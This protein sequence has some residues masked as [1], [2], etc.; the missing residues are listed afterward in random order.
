MLLIQRR[1]YSFIPKQEYRTCQQILFNHSINLDTDHCCY[2]S[3]FM[4]LLNPE[5]GDVWKICSKLHIQE[6][7]SILRIV[8]ALTPALDEAHWKDLLSTIMKRLLNLHPK[9]IVAFKCMS[10]LYFRLYVLASRNAAVV[11]YILQKAI[12]IGWHQCRRSIN[13]QYH[14]LIPNIYVFLSVN[15]P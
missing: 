13:I 8:W 15:W 6:C 2:I 11:N 4:A 14:Y 5:M 3:F 7:N 10:I 12:K 9:C 1:S